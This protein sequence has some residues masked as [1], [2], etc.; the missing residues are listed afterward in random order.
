Q[1]AGR[2]EPFGQAG[3][4]L[5]QVGKAGGEENRDIEWWPLA[6]VDEQ[7]DVVGQG[8]EG[9]VEPGWGVDEGDAVAGFD[10]ELLR[11]RRAGVA[12][13]GCVLRGRTASRAV[14]LSQMARES[15]PTEPA[16]STMM[17]S[18]AAS[19]LNIRAIIGRCGEAPA[20]AKPQAA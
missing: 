13:H 3:E 15:R 6:R 14:A 2:G 16:N 18:G 9:L 1:A 7:L 8:S 20:N 4:S 11:K 17:D 5:F 19:E 12:G 10:A